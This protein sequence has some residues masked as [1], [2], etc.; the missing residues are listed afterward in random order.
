[1]EILV[2]VA[3]LVVLIFALV[4]LRAIERALVALNHETYQVHVSARKI[5]YEL[6]EH[7]ETIKGHVS[8]TS[9]CVDT[10]DRQV[11]E[12]AGRS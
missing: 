10:I 9:E 5:E 8:K 6:C 4:Q 3:I 2:Q 1:M 11:Q 12:I 7:G